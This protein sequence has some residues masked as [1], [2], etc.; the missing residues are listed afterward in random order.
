[1][2]VRDEGNTKSDHPTDEFGSVATEGATSHEQ[3]DVNTASEEQDISLSLV[4]PCY[5]ETDVF[6]TSM[7]AIDMFFEDLDWDYEY[8]FV[9][10]ASDDGTAALVEEYVEENSHARAIFHEENRG[11]GRSVADGIR[12]A[13]NPIVG[14][15]DIDLEVTIHQL[16]PLVRAVQNGADVL[17][18]YRHYKQNLSRL[19]RLLLSVGYKHLARLVIDSPF[20]DP[21]AGC[22]FF[23]RDKIL[24]VIEETHS[25]HWFWDTEVMMR[26]H[27]AGLDVREY[28]VLFVGNDE[29][30][31]TVD[32]W[33]DIPDYLRNLWHFRRE[34]YSKLV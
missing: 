11:R 29:A 17:C 8:V 22:K 31:S 10:D 26:A 30:G 6:E 4:L 2:T 25:D 27:N 28:P 24:P 21:E 9:E 14:Y 5:H 33:S 16:Y 19:H 34:N 32:I 15:L 18:G 20:N 23:K 12:A 7:A 1:M 3:A 13:S